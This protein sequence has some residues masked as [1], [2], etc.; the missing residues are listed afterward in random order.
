MLDL[1]HPGQFDAV[2]SQTLRQFLVV[3]RAWAAVGG[4]DP[5]RVSSLGKC[6]WFEV[7]VRIEVALPHGCGYR[8]WRCRLALTLRRRKALRYLCYVSPASQSSSYSQP[9]ALFTSMAL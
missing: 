4:S 5:V 9:I 8:R 7:V 6:E 3:C 2:I 1:R